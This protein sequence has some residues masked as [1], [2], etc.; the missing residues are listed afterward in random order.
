MAPDGL[1]AALPV[2]SSADFLFK[3]IPDE[4]MA[5]E[6]LNDAFCVDIRRLL[7]EGMALQFGDN[8]SGIL[9]CQA[10]HDQIVIPTL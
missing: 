1:F 6:Q 7:H 10:T 3:T 5:T 9:C 8:E 4:E 2:P